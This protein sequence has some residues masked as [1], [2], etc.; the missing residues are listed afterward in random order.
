M[1]HIFILFPLFLNFNFFGILFSG[2]RIISTTRKDRVTWLT[3]F[4]PNPP[5]QPMFCSIGDVGFFYLISAVWSAA[6]ASWFPR[7]LPVRMVRV[8]IQNLRD[9]I[10]LSLTLISIATGAVWLGSARLGSAV[11]FFGDLVG[12]LASTQSRAGQFRTKT[13]Q[14]SKSMQ[15]NQPI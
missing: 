14:I 3:A 10:G 11:A 5:T 15:T 2:W 13:L 7:R 1:L 6:S 9:C 8:I 12:F 4:S